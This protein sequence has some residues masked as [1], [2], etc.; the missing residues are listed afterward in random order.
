MR[1]ILILFCIALQVLAL[2][3]MVFGR[4]SVV[5]NGE[6]IYLRTAP[7]DPRDPF[8]GD[9]VR[10][11][12]PMNNTRNIAVR[13]SNEN[14]DLKAAKGDKV[15]AVLNDT[16]SGVH[17]AE[18]ITTIKPTEG[19]YIRGRVVTGR[20]G[21]SLDNFLQNNSQL[22]FGI[23]QL[24][25]EQGSGI[26]IENKQG[27]RGGLQVPMEVEVAVGKNGLGIV[28]GYRWSALGIDLNFVDPVEIEAE[29]ETET[30]AE[31]ATQQEDGLPDRYIE[32]TI[33]N[34]SD[35]V[36]VLDNPGNN[37]G[38]TLEPSRPQFSAFRQ[39]PSACDNDLPPNHMML[40]SGETFA[41]NVNLADPRWQVINDSNR[42][43]DIR[44]LGAGELFRI[45]YRTPAGSEQGSSAWIGELPSRAF[46]GAGIID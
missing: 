25:V 19:L 45:V 13:W 32:I 42:A 26:D 10:L 29:T 44:T 2:A 16:S 28:T 17:R 7:I 11:S 14:E 5:R 31:T 22:K 20:D 18:Y 9:F 37:C 34:V 3:T 39:A 8:R 4:E 6:R 46:S 15:Y 41:F 27:L 23:E 12:Y 30:E 24:F 35:A 1:K 21:G 40:Q 36:V 38:F 43:I 33:E